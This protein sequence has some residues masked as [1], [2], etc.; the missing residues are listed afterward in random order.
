M[1]MMTRLSPSLIRLLAAP[2]LALM[3]AATLSACASTEEAPYVERPVETIYSE[4]ATAMD[5]ERYKEAARLFDEVERQHP[6]SQWATRAQLMSAFAHYQALQYDDALIALDRFI[7]LHPGSEDIAYA[8]YMKGLCYYEQ[9]TDVGR[10]QR[11]TQQALDALGELT[12]RF[13]E[14]PYSRDAALKI[15]LTNDHL[16]GKEMEIGRYYLRQGYQNAAIGR[17]RTVIEKYQTTSHVPEALHRLTEAYLALG[18]VDEAQAAAA[19]LGHNF[20]GSEWYV[21]SYALLVDANV[22]PASSSKSWISR[23]WASVF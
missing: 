23:A 20:P 10:D 16:A 12:R 18:V 17:F 22:R 2:C 9:I 7:Q 5:Q 4:A 14:S 8:Y 11:V 21:D 1:S 13:P 6:Y 19:V 15:D 3:M